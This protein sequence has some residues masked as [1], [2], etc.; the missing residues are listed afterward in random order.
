[1][2]L[3][4]PNQS[5][6]PRRTCVSRDMQ[7]NDTKPVRPSAMLTIKKNQPQWMTWPLKPATRIPVKNPNGAQPP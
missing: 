6:D 4:Q 2:L 5:I 3:P 1:M 7:K